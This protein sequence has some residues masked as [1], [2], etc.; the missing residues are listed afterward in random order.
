M[1]LYRRIPKRGFTNIWRV[2]PEI[3]NVGDLNI[4]DDGTEVTTEMLKEKGLVKNIKNG[5]KVLGDGKLEK[6]LTVRADKFSKS[7]VEQITGAGGKAETI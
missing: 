7:A 6:N 4:F 2:E 3:V 5:V 1:P